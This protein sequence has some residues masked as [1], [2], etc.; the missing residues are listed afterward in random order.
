V[1]NS[2][3]LVPELFVA[4]SWF[5]GLNDGAL[6]QPASLAQ[7]PRRNRIESRDPQQPGPPAE[8]RGSA[9]ARGGPTKAG[10]AAQYAGDEG[11]ERDPRVVF[12]E[13]FEEPTLEA[14]SLHWQSVKNVENMSFSKDAPPGSRGKHSL[15]LTHVGAKGDG[16]HLYRNLNPGYAKLHARFYVKFDPDCV[17][18]HH[19]GTNMGGYNPPTPWPQGGAGLRPG[20]DKTFTVGIEPFGREWVWDY[21]TYWCEM[22]GSPPR[23]QTW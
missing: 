1:M 16:G 14:L 11:I 2:L 3:K 22:R 5:L 20:G 15:Q 21:Y 12:A 23:G 10:I 18:I 7:S 9:T 17:P 19:F 6:G 13:N 4:C 8:S